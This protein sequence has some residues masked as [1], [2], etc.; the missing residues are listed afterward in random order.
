MKETGILADKEGRLVVPKLEIDE[1]LKMNHD[2]MLSG[3]LGS[4]KTLARV[5]RQYVWP[6][7]GKDVKT[8]VKNCL[9]C[10][11]RKD[12]GSSKAQLKPIALIHRVWDLIA[13]YIVGPITESRNGNKYILVLRHEICYDIS[14][15]ESNGTSGS[16]NLS[17]RNH[18]EIWCT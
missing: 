15:G 12:Y 8:Y 10:A 3:H 18:F 2:H 6:G 4:A 9:T 13:M 14:T 1:I 11:K 16:E 17:C 5:R 7:M